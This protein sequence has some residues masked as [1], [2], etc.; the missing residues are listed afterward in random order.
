MDSFVVFAFRTLLAAKR[1][2]CLEPIFT[3]GILKAGTSIIPLDEL[4]M[5]AA[6]C[7]TELK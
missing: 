6:A 1:P 7:F 2:F 4:P 3:V 5:T